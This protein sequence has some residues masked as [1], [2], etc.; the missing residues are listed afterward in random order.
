MGRPDDYAA[1]LSK[2]QVA[3]ARWKLAND[4]LDLMARDSVPRDT[5]SHQRL[6]VARAVLEDLA[7]ALESDQLIPARVRP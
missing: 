2:S 7:T 6:A 5:E 3:F 4:M 1:P